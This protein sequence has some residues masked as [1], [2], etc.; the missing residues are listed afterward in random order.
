MCLWLQVWPLTTGHQQGGSFL[1]EVNSHSQQSCVAC[2]TSQAYAVVSDIWLTSDIFTKSL[3]RKINDFVFASIGTIKSHHERK[4]WHYEGTYFLNN[5]CLSPLLNR[6]DLILSNRVFWMWSAVVDKKNLLGDMYLLIPKF[7]SCVHYKLRIG[8]DVSWLNVA[9][10]KTNINRHE[11]EKEL[12][13][14]LRRKWELLGVNRIF[15]KSMGV[16]CYM[17]VPPAF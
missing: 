4:M 9:R 11:E 16:V 1:E 6:S 10:I 15:L 8:I 14:Y 3:A 17:T 5:L 13:I 7:I 12:F 2:R